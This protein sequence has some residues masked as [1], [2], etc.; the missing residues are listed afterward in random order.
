MNRL[1]K[2]I[3]TASGRL[4][5]PLD[6]R[7]EE[8]VIQDIA[9]AL[10]NMVRWTG[11]VSQFYS[12]AQHAVMVSELVESVAPH[13]ALAALH[14][15]SAEAYLSDICSPTKEFLFFHYENYAGVQQVD[16]F[17][18]VEN[19]VEAAIFKALDIPA[20]MP[21][22]RA[23]IKAADR[24]ALRLEA[25]HL[26]HAFP[27]DDWLHTIGV[28]DRPWADG[29]EPALARKQFLYRHLALTQGS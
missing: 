11:H 9:H 27:A 22:D 23:V 2:Y 26:M 3:Q 13:L 20:L 19:R 29:V 8:V 4:F 5:W 14:H 28:I 15:D 10:S 12:V 17:H 16:S 25:E 6:P 7:T 1:G 24:A 21:G 18:E